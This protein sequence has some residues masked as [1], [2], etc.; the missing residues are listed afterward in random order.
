[1][2][3][4]GAFKSRPYLC[5]L[6]VGNIEANVLSQQLSHTL[7]ELR[8]KIQKRRNELPQTCS[9]MSGWGGRALPSAVADDRYWLLHSVLYS[10]SF[11]LR[12]VTNRKASGFIR[13]DKN[14]NCF[15][16]WV[17]DVRLRASIWVTVFPQSVVNVLYIY[18]VKQVIPK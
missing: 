10:S 7:A 2:I 9:A 4:S 16:R 11:F 6:P 18:V 17:I 8:A 15:L 14:V 12:T 13:F 3:Q 1:M 5:S